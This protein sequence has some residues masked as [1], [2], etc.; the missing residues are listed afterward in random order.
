MKSLKRINGGVVFQISHLLGRIYKYRK[1]MVWV[2]KVLFFCNYII[3]G[4][5]LMDEEI[6]GK[7]KSYFGLGAMGVVVCSAAAFYIDLF[8]D[9]KRDVF[10]AGI[11]FAGSIIG[12]VF[13]L[14]GVKMT[15]RRTEEVEFIKVYFNHRLMF[16]N[17]L[18][19]IRDIELR[20]QQYSDPQS[21]CIYY[22]SQYKKIDKTIN[23]IKL[24]I[25]R[26]VAVELHQIQKE[27]EK[28]IINNNELE[29][30]NR[31]EEEYLSNL[32]KWIM[33]RAEAI[34]SSQ[35][36]INK[37]KE[38]IDQKKSEKYQ[39]FKLEF[40]DLSEAYKAKI[41]EIENCLERHIYALDKQY[42]KIK[43]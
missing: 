17:A 39:E 22:N 37:E 1:P 6:T 11:G 41:K 28:I 20:G 34:N 9:I 21:K 35:E 2:G 26:S 19:A 10:I 43:I 36:E 40:R 14:I 30:K 27:L 12:G 4:D 16:E 29:L 5:T 3:L 32:E 31:K 18:D 13:T 8:I 42:N 15:L 23:E 25:G 38:S 24:Q 7:F 33:G